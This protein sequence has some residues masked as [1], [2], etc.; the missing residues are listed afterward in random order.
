M[1]EI[2]KHTVFSLATHCNF[3]YIAG[4]FTIQHIY[5]DKNLYLTRM[6]R[7]CLWQRK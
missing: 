6:L 2:I 5:L 7:I 1:S 3:C 4:T